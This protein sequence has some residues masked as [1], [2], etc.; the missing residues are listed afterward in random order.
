MR[1]RSMQMNDAHI[2]CTLEQFEAEFMAVI[3]LYLKYFETFG[4]TKYQMR[5]SLHSK[6]EL[7][8]NM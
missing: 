6:E 1:V 3:D 2:Y 7:G 5:L 4:I 8:K